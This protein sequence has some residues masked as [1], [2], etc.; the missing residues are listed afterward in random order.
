MPISAAVPQFLAR[1]AGRERFAG[2]PRGDLEAALQ[3]LVTVARAAWPGVALEADVFVAHLAERLP[4]EGAPLGL[5]AETRAADLYLACACAEGDPRAHAAFE[6]V[7]LARARVA[8]ASFEGKG[9]TV[10]DALQAVREKLLLGEGGERG[11]I[12]DYNG[13]GSLEAWVKVALMRTALNLN[14][15]QHHERPA[16][17]GDLADEP[18]LGADDPELDAMK[19]EH[20]DAFGQALRE[21]LAGLPV[22]ERNLLRLYLVDRLNIAAI[23]AIFKVH[24]AT[25]ARWIADVRAKVLEGTHARLRQRLQV[26]DSDADSLA[27]LVRSQLDVSVL[28]LL[29]SSAR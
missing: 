27:R 6:R 20:R 25:I 21:S 1:V 24:R 17:D 5:L 28:R 14:R 11:R 12:V 22:E 13:A 9:S 7:V 23:G 10:E 16:F 15:G 18:L 3:A 8:L 2:V 4:A 26:S 19:R 29:R